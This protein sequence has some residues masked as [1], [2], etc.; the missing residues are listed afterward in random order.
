MSGY[1]EQLKERTSQC[2]FGTSLG[3]E[4]VEVAPG[5]AR[6]AA[7]VQPQHY[8]WIGRTHGGWLLSLADQACS[9]GGNTVPGNYVAIQFNMHFVGSPDT[10]DRVEAECRVVHQGKSLGLVEVRVTGR[11][12]RLLA[13]GSSNVLRIGDRAA[14]PEAEGPKE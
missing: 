5:Y 9:I 11:D 4:V 8:N 1:L 10:G 12:G 3:F 14:R 13:Y 2:P 7:T 6:V